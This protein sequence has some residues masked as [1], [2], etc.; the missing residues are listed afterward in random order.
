MAT[1]QYDA[2]FIATPCSSYSVAHRPQL[3]S[4]RHPEGTPTT[5]ASWAAYLAKH[6]RLA[7]WTARLIEA[8]GA[9][10]VPWA[11][12]NPADRGQ[13]GSPA[14]WPDKAD[15]APLWIQPCILRASALTAARSRT[16]SQCSF[17][18]SVQKYTTVMH[19]PLLDAQLGPLDSRQCAHMAEG[20]AHAHVAHGVDEGGRS[21]AAAAAA[22]PV[23]LNEFLAEALLAGVSALEAATLAGEGGGDGGRQLASG[24]GGR[25]RPSVV[26]PGAG[27]LRRGEAHTR[28]VCLC[29]QPQGGPP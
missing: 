19:S 12:E 7:E 9:A 8:A 26:R 25:R 24:G 10:G 29:A 4:R 23:A 18:A 17:H 22:Y 16:F 5:T 2:V 21:R 13:R 28:Q 27:A 11:L 14:W 3:R 15:H 1:W 20:V 6:N